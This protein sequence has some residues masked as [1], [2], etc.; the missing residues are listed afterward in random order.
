MY[1]NPVT[2]SKIWLRLFILNN[3]FVEKS[4][5]TPIASK[6]T[7]PDLRALHQSNTGMKVGTV[8]GTNSDKGIL[9]T[10]REFWS[11]GALTGA[12]IPP[13]LIGFDL[14]PSSIVCAIGGGM[15][16]KIGNMFGMNYT[17][18]PDLANK[19]LY[20]DD[21]EADVGARRR[22]RR[23]VHKEYSPYSVN[24]PLRLKD[25]MEDKAN[26]LR[27]EKKFLNSKSIADGS[28]AVLR[29]GIREVIKSSYGKENVDP[30]FIKSEL[31]ALDKVIADEKKV[32]EE[33]GFVLLQ[34]TSDMVKGFNSSKNSVAGWSSSSPANQL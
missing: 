2:S 10:C 33:K 11:I 34:V 14:L 22:G 28:K 6:L 23:A 18:P 25:K 9:V 19:K 21:L 30:E 4:F 15:F 31:D 16:G 5:S 20:E 7:S 17:D 1:G 13:S 12:G 27:E 29:D 8:I 3:L 24:K 26:R 32:E